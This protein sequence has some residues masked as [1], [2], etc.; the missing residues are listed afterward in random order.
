LIRPGAAAAWL[1]AATLLAAGCASAPP[2]APGGGET[3]GFAD[4]AAAWSLPAAELATQRLFRVRYDGPDEGGS[5]RLTLSLLTADRFQVRA[6]D[7]LGR[8]LWTLDAAGGEGLWLDHRNRLVCR[9]EGRFDV[10]AARLTPFPLPALPALLLGRLPSPPDG[11]VERLP[12]GGAGAAD[13]LDYRDAAGRRWTARIEAGR[14]V[15]W[16]LWEEGE[17]AVWWQRRDGEAF[18]SDRERGSQLRWRETLREPLP[19]AAGGLAAPP[20]PDGYR[21]VD[22]AA[23]YAG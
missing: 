16:A 18:L 23:A 6:V 14:P 22:C 4:L 19:A 5:F 11:A 9:L 15:S 1:L 21:A 3:P 10:A 13:R 12:A 2:P 20:V 17:A 8:A 7:P